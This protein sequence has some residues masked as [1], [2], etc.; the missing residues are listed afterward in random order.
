MDPTAD[1]Q[2]ADRLVRVRRESIRVIGGK[3]IEQTILPERRRRTENY[4]AM[5]VG[6]R[7]TIEA[8]KASRHVRETIT[9]D[10]VGIFAQ[11]PVYPK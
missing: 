10:Q 4:R 3:G 7:V 8:E 9:F 2:I 1:V 11:E 6:T 5:T